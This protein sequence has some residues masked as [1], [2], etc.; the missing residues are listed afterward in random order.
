[1]TDHQLKHIEFLK[2]HTLDSAL[3]DKKIADDKKAC[4]A[5]RK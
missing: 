4:Y 3:R 5:S 2:R 1:M